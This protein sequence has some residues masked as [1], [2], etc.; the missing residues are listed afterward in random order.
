M[1]FIIMINNYNSQLEMKGRNA[2]ILQNTGFV[3][4]SLPVTRNLVS[5]V[6]LSSDVFAV[7]AWAAG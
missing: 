6:G 5:T 3:A 1:H 2:E 7:V 4:A